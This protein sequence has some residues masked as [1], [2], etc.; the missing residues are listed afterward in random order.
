MIEQ[1]K[2]SVAPMMAY[3][4]RHFRVL[5]RLINRQILLYT[6]MVTTGSL[7]HGESERHLLFSPI[8]RPLALQLGGSDPLELAKCSQ[9]AEELQYDEVNL[10]VGCPSD[11]VRAGQFGACLMKT[12]SLVADCVSAMSQAVKIPV[13][14]KTRIGVDNQDSYSALQNFV[15]TISAAGCRTFIIHARKAWLKGLSPR[16]NRTVPPLNYEMVYHLKKDFPDLEIIINGGI[17]TLAEID[18]HLQQVD[19]VMIGRKAYDNPLLLA[20]NPELTPQ[21]VIVNYLPYVLEQLCQGGSLWPM[22]RHLMGL[23]QGQRGAKQWRQW[24]S[25]WR[26]QEPNL[27]KMYETITPVLSEISL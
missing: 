14:V 22:S 1:R 11:R 26:T 19:G 13:T 12:P 10:N 5:M 24:L 2:I 9:M 3:T 15:A 23:F 18:H 27:E 16:Q 21:E 4:D 8:E 7:I 25:G 17:N 20:E 6:E